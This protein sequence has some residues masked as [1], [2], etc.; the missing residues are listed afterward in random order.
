M[1]SYVNLKSVQNVNPS[2]ARQIKTLR[3]KV[4][5]MET[6]M[7]SCSPG[8]VVSGMSE[9]YSII[10]DLKTSLRAAYSETRRGEERIDEHMYNSIK[11]EID[12]VEGYIKSYPKYF[13]NKCECVRK[14]SR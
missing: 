5:L 4:E 6:G 8:E 14:Q 13:S 3:S 1:A 11:A 10:P 12:D 7:L 9:L 2:L